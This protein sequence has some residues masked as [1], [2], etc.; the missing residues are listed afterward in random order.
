MTEDNI[1][2]RVLPLRGVLPMSCYQASCP[3]H[4]CNTIDSTNTTATCIPYK[5][6]ALRFACTIS[7]YSDTCTLNEVLSSCLDSLFPSQRVTLLPKEV[8]YHIPPGENVNIKFSAMECDYSVLLVGTACCKATC[9]PRLTLS[10]KLVYYGLT[11]CNTLDNG[12]NF[13]LNLVWWL[14]TLFVGKNRSN[15]HTCA[16]CAICVEEKTAVTNLTNSSCP[17]LHSVVQSVPSYEHACR[18][19]AVESPMAPKW[20]H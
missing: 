2:S 10:A 12:P 19:W 11:I 18:K 8:W 14:L 5:R 13:R 4:M 16:M 15:N 3:S 1:H 6:I 9:W 20:W 17:P 7:A